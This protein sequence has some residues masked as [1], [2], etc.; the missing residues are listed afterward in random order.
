MSMSPPESTSRPTPG[1]PSHLTYADYLGLNTLL[2]LQV[3]Q[4]PDTVDRAVVLSE[5][6]FIVTHQACE[7]W[8]KQIVADLEAAVDTLDSQFGEGDP[9][10][11]AEYLLRVDEL[12]RVLQQQLVALEKLPLRHFAAFRPY[13]GSASGAQ[14]VQFAQLH[15]L[16]GDDQIPGRLYEAYLVALERA[17][18]SVMEVCHRGA[19]AGVLHRIAESLMDIGNDYWRWK[20][21]H[22]ALMSRTLGN[23]P[24]TAGT[25]GA[26]YLRARITLPFTELRRMR[27]Q[28]HDD[29]ARAHAHHN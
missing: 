11:A 6:F 5:Q 9:E 4:T 28:V 22:L 12:F 15:R 16:L 20:V 17:G 21:G 7:L 29:F 10:V 2:S 26:A 18:T 13:L 1:A 24:G 23:K 8:L 3:P 19:P 27:S 14:S 25:T